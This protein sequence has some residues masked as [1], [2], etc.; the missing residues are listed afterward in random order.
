MLCRNYGWVW[1]T[2]RVILWF[3]RV[4]K[5]TFLLNAMRYIYVY[6]YVCI[7]LFI[8]YVCMYVY[9]YIVFNMSINIRICMYHIAW[10]VSIVV[11]FHRRLMLE[12]DIHRR[13]SIPCKYKRTLSAKNIDSWYSV[14]ISYHNTIIKVTIW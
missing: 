8:Y 1:N 7:Y 13:Y 3:V 10:N 4:F 11:K 5:V 14:H 6:V 9:I 2:C 12:K